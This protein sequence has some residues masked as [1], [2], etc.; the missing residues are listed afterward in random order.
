VEWIIVIEF[1]VLLIIY[2]L[3]REIL[4]EAIL[5]VHL[6]RTSQIDIEDKIT[7]GC[8]ITVHVLFLIHPT[9]QTKTLPPLASLF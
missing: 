7:Y 5:D 9:V 6:I 8:Y 1:K 3:I 2:Y 4:A